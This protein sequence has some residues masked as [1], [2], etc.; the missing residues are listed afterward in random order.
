MAV[1]E[2]FV[3]LIRVIPPWSDIFDLL[4]LQECILAASHVHFIFRYLGSYI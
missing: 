4:Q 2:M 1:V 3:E